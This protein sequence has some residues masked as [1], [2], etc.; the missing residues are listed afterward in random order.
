MIKETYSG[1]ANREEA[2]RISEQIDLLGKKA[3]VE[4][5]D[6]IRLRLAVEEAILALD[7]QYD[8]KLPIKFQI[9]QKM[10]SYLFR[11]SYIAE[12]YNP[13]SEEEQ[14]TDAWSNQMLEKIGQKPSYRQKGNFNE[15]QFIIPKKHFKQE[16]YILIAVGLSVLLGVF[17]KLIPEVVRTNIAVYGLDLISEIFLRLLGVFS[18]LI[19]FFALVNG[20]CGMGSVGDFSKVGRSII[21]RYLSLSFLGGALLTVPASFLFHLQWGGAVDGADIPNQI[22]EI[23]LSI[24]PDSPIDPFAKGD[25]LQIIFLAVFIGVIML[26]LGNRVHSFRDGVTQAND[27]IAKALDIIC[28]FLPIFIFSSLLSTFWQLGFGIILSLW[29]PIV[30]TVSL[31]LVVPVWKLIYIAIRYHISPFLII[32]RLL[33]SVF[34]SFSTASTIASYSSIKED[35]IKGLGVE[36]KFVE[37]SFPIGMNLYTT[38]Y[39]LIYLNT[40]LFM[41]Q[42][43]ETP[44]SVIWLVMAGFFSVVF[45]IATPNVSGGALICVGVMMKNL[46][47]PD[48]ALALAGTLIIV[49][50]FYCTAARNLSHEL[51]VFLQAK[52]FGKVDESVLQRK[53]N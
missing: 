45:C 11:L 49:L 32:R 24:F 15:L 43:Y 50:D 47:M 12:P 51:D 27:L 36:E 33:K 13:F 26:A 3:R 37:F 31:G 2:D 17:G 28:K 29:K 5:K 48:S 41:A 10:E 23:I 25:M 40:V 46:N 52:K 7:Q 20:I 9:E 8:G 21:I 14:S 38:G 35:L 30:I 22:K 4:R 53:G 34:V 19:I 6:I 44:A 18:G 39:A 42:E 1:V 16:V